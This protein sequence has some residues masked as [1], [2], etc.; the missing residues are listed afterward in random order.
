M[1]GSGNGREVRRF[2]ARI[3]MI[4][5]ALVMIVCGIALSAPSAGHG[6]SA[7]G[8]RVT[9]RALVYPLVANPGGPYTVGR[10]KEVQLDGS[11]STPADQIKSYRWT[12]KVAH[13]PPGVQLRSVAK[14]GARASIV[15]LCSITATL[16][17]SDGKGRSN[18]KSTQINVTARELK[19]IPFSQN[20]EANV[21]MPFEHPVLAFGLNRSAEVWSKADKAEPLAANDRW[22]DPGDRS[23]A[24][25][26]KQVR[27]PGGP[28]DRFWY[29]TDHHLKVDRVIILNRQLLHGGRVWLLNARHRG[30]L[31][32]LVT[33][34]RRHE[35]IHGTLVQNAL[36]GG[37]IGLPRLEEA[38]GSTKEALLG[39]I[40]F[41][42][43]QAETTLKNVS[44]ETKVHA[45]MRAIYGATAVR[46]AVPGSSGTERFALATLGDS[47]GGH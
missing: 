17:V 38:V 19:K 5:A 44:S 25:E 6:G 7:P 22:L 43:G 16:T 47:G 1:R 10:A 9:V 14:S 39:R 21:K 26:L 31:S 20:H 37:K 32:Q 11:K 23:K 36:K 33:A 3:C 4:S 8:S 41:V 34:T 24:V 46:I 13:C 40:R 28:F 27:D 42:L 29:V 18:A 30:P 45:A 15:G 2:A 12:F 35:Q